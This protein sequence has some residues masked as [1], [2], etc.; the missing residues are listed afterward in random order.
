MSK[1]KSITFYYSSDK[2]DLHGIQ[3]FFKKLPWSPLI[4]HWRKVEERSNR[5]REVGNGGGGVGGRA[6]DST[7]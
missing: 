3:T 7:Q 2:R 5:G 4:N 1:L 6:F